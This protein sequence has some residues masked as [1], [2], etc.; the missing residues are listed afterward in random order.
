MKTKLASALLLIFAIVMLMLSVPSQKVDAQ[1]CNS[2]RECPSGT[3]TEIYNFGCADGCCGSSYGNNRYC[4]VVELKC[5]YGGGPSYTLVV[6]TSCYQP[7]FGGPQLCR[8]GLQDDE[9]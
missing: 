1:T 8:C 3:T 6:S 4:L 7:T 9:L 5:L 2:V